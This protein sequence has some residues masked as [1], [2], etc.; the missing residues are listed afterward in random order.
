MRKH[1]T[2]AVSRVVY[3]IDDKARLARF[4]MIRLGINR[5]R[6]EAPTPAPVPSVDANSYLYIDQRGRV[7]KRARPMRLVG[8]LLIVVGLLMLVG[9]GAWYGYQQWDNQQFVQELAAKGGHVD[10]PIALADA[11]T[12]TAT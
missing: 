5:R 7:R 10:P 11:P 2:V 6:K 1:Q 8:N 12:P 3:W 9:I 4:I